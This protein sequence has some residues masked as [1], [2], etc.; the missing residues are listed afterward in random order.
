V[1]SISCRFCGAELG[2][3]YVSAQEEEQRYKVGKYILETKRVVR[4]VEWEEEAEEVE[5]DEEDEVLFD[6]QDEEECEDL[7][8]GIWSEKLARRRRREKGWRA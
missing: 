7:F 3:R 4:S 6:S 8:M 1:A 2:W 5:S